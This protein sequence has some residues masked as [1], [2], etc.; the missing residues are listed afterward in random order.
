[1]EELRRFRGGSFGGALRMKTEKAF[2]RGKLVGGAAVLAVGSIAAKL[3]GAFYRVPLTNMIGAEGMG[4]YQLVFPVYVLFMTLSTAG[5]PTALSRIVAEHRARGESA[6]KYLAAALMT[7]AAL[8]A[9]AGILLTALS[10]VLARWQ[11]NP[12]AAVGYAAIAPSVFFVGIIAGLR[13]WFQGE[14]Y[15]IPTAVSGIIEQVVKLGA[16][17]GLAAAFAQKGL[18]ASVFGALAGVTLSEFAAAIY[19]SVTYFM[20]ARKAKWKREPL[21]PDAAERRAMFRTAFPIALLGVILPI[22]AFADSLIV[23]NAMKWGGADTAAATAAY[24]LFGG[25]VASLVNLPVVVVMSLAIAVVPSVAVSRAEHDVSGI[26]AKSRISIKL[27]YLIGV[28]SSLFLMVFGKDMLSLM[29]PALSEYETELAARLLAVS[30]FG[31]VP[32]GAT[33]IYVSLLQALDK[34]YSAVKTLFCAV[35]FKIVLSLSLVGYLGIMGAAVAGVGMSALSLGMLAVCFRRLTDLRTE[36]YVAKTLSA[37]VI[38]ALAAVVVAEYVPTR[39]GALAAGTVVCAAV[40]GWLVML[41][42]VFTEEECLALPFGS[43]ILSLR[44]K[45]RFWE[46]GYDG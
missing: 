21:R 15:M 33:Q 2:R 1:M 16:G 12:S 28:P 30:A 10:G 5:I 7:L 42:G 11:G 36:K 17:V 25:P 8:S 35:L 32:T 13:G 6:K 3:I 26:L 9:L 39:I 37:G 4:M 20:R 31:V 24:G 43:R 19:L 14:M 38:M 45:I 44:R 27:V 34:T 29:Y 41:M 40:Y 22:G 23:V 18:Q 46:N